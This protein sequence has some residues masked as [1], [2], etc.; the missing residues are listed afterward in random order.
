MYGFVTLARVFSSVDHSFIT[1]W[2][3]QQTPLLARVSSDTRQVLT[4]LLKDDVGVDVVEMNET[5]RLDVLVT[6]QW[7]KTLAWRLKCS[8]DSCSQMAVLNGGDGGL[9]ACRESSCII[10]ASK[11]LLHI[12]NTASTPSLEAHGIGMVRRH[13]GT[14]PSANPTSCCS[15]E[16]NETDQQE[17]KVSDVANCLCEVL[18]T[19]TE[20]EVA[21][22]FFSTQDFLHQFMVFLADFR[23]RESQYLQPLLER[24][25]R[26]LSCCVEPQRALLLDEET[27]VD[28]MC[29][30]L[31]KEPGEQMAS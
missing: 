21:L 9:E 25:T 3:N 6:Q 23:R 29:E 8:V 4:R 11:N 14:L 5:Q 1:A 19:S 20:P 24:A 10:T 2:R 31:V 26:S 30:S 12:V 15:P 22:E 27:E 7:L 28:W 18:E 13:P 17:Q 16:T